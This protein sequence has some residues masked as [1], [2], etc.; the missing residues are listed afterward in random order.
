MCRHLAYV[1][2]PRSLSALL[3]DPPH[4][5]YQQAH[6]PRRQR[7]GTV[8][9][10]GF[11]AGWYVPGR[12]EPVRYRR[13]QPIWAD[14]SFA[15]LAPTVAST[16]VLGAVRSATAGFP[17][18]ESCAA[19]FTHDRWLLSHNGRAFD[20]A[21]LRKTLADDVAWVP[22]ALGPVDSAFLFGIAVARW[23]GGASLGAGL[24][25]VVGAAAGAGDG[26]LTLLA[27]D[28]D[29]VAGTTWGEPLYVLRT[30]DAVVVAA[31][32]HDDDPAWHEVPDR[33]LVVADRETVTVTPLEDAQ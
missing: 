19:P 8:N 11:G 18:D 9:A 7:Y 10:D 14:P 30:P 4:S 1:G 5:L 20:P 22:D 13:A 26:R 27:T 29:A 6:A 23:T 21:L 32:P 2:T 33:S 28:G 31:E 3:L 16:C 17:T 12:L 15:S 24:A 25:G